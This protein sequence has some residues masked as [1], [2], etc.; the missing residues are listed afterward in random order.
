MK[1]TVY[2]T[3]DENQIQI[4][5]NRGANYILCARSA[6]IFMLVS[7]FSPKTYSYR[8]YGIWEYFLDCFLMSRVYVFVNVSFFSLCTHSIYFK[9]NLVDYN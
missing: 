7:W 3:L 9:I 2:S 1:I 8:V 4:H 6:V 5:Q